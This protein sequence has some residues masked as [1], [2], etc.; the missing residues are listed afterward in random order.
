MDHVVV[1]LRTFK[2]HLVRLKAVL[3]RIKRAG[4]TVNP[5]KVQLAKS[6]VGLLGFDSDNWDH[7]LNVPN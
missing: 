5:K 6:N 4:L 2:E 3:D 1:F 7:R